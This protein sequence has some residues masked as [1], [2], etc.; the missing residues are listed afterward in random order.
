MNDSTQVVVGIVVSTVLFTAPAVAEVT[1]EWA[2]VWNVSNA[3]DPLNSAIVPGIGSV[4][5]EFRIAKYNVTNDQYAEFL[6]AVAKTDTN[7]LFNG[8]MTASPHGGITQ[9]GSSGSFA[10]AVKSNMGNKPVIYVSFFDA[11]RFVNWLHNGQPTGLQDASTTEVG[12]YAISDGLSETRAGDAQFF[13]PTESEWYKAAYYQPSAQGGDSDGYWL[14]AT[15]SNSAPTVATASATGD[16]SNPGANVANYDNGADWNGQDGTLTTVGSAGGSSESFY[17]TSDQ[18]GNVF[19]WNETVLSPT[20]RGLRGG[21]YNAPATIVRSTF[22]NQLMPTTEGNIFGFRV[23]S[24]VP[25]E[26]VPATSQWGL[27]VLVLL[28]LTTGTMMQGKKIFGRQH[29]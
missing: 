25:P 15:A 18:C 19:D 8:Q 11:M 22:R 27:A 17:G 29:P 21:S 3:A 23:A 10:Y 16:I 4:G 20:T 26:I 24:P 1:F 2:T 6:N 13:I 28:I 7:S 12:V 9:S 14:Y 5:Y